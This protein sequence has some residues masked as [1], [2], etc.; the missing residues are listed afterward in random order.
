MYPPVLDLA[1]GLHNGQRTVRIPGFRFAKLSRTGILE[2][3]T[4]FHEEVFPA[5]AE[6]VTPVHVGL[7]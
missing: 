1:S 7:R 6:V 4:T 2:R 3:S 5:A